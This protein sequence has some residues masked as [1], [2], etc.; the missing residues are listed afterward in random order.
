[1]RP[2]SIR[3][4]TLFTLAAAALVLVNNLLF[5]DF[6][7]AGLSA[8]PRFGDLAPLVP[9]SLTATALVVPLLLCYL[10]VVRRSSA[11]RWII[12]GVVLF[13]TYGVVDAVGRFP[14]M[15]VTITA[16]A[17]ALQVVGVFFLFTHPARQWFA[18]SG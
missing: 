9:A 11:A 1:M 6:N 17:L 2:T 10:V 16:S 8:D 14:P 18:R 12:G 13:W 5:W 7:M 3:L 4:F 15:M